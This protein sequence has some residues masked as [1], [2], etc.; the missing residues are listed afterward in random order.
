MKFIPMQDINET[1]LN[2][3]SI[4]YIR[5]DQ[6]QD[7]TDCEIITNQGRVKAYSFAIGLKGVESELHLYYRDQEYRLTA[8]SLLRDLI[9]K[10]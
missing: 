4:S 6:L 7:P 10:I 1:V 3:D 8:I 5:F 9:S 2:S